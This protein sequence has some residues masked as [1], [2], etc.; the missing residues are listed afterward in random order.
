MQECPTESGNAAA[1][2]RASNCSK[3]AAVGVMRG[4][5]SLPVE[6]PEGHGLTIPRNSVFDARWHFD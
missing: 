5:S 6:S 2:W 3:K 4:N 1:R